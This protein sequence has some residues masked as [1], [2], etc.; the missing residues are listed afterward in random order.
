MIAKPPLTVFPHRVGKVII[1]GVLNP[2]YWAVYPRYLLLPCEPHFTT[3]LIETR[4]P[5]DVFRAHVSSWTSLWRL[6]IAF[7][8]SSPIAEG[9]EHQNAWEPFPRRPV[10]TRTNDWLALR[11]KTSLERT[12]VVLLA[13]GLT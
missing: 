1:D 12:F 2:K 8:T 5:D 4:R 9:R 6:E 3:R 10:Y 13:L 11:V 7:P